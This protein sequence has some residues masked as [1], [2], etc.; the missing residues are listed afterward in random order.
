MFHL[1]PKIKMEGTLIEL[2]YPNT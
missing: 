1:L 2:K